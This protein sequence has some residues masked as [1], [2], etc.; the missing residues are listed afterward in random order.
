M[1]PSEL[2]ESS[3]NTFSYRTPPVAVSNINNIWSSVHKK[4]KQRWGWAEI[5]RCLCKKRAFWIRLC[6]IWSLIKIIKKKKTRKLFPLFKTFII[7]GFY[8]VTLFSS[9]WTEYMNM[10]YTVGPYGSTFSITKKFYSGPK[11]FMQCC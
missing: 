4:V 6:N 1:L 5:K 11:T 7:P 3:K 2:C 8:L 10:R 9:I